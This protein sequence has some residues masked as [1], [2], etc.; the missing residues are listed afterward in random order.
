MDVDREQSTGGA[1]GDAGSYSRDFQPI[2]GVTLDELRS[3]VTKANESPATANI[4]IDGLRA[5]IAENG[6]DPD[7]VIRAALA[8]EP[9]VEP[10]GTEAGLAHAMADFQGRSIEVKAPELEQI[11]II[12]RLQR[13][14]S[15]AANNQNIDA[16]K[17][18]DL[19][20][21]ALRAITTVVVKPED[22]KLIEDMWLDGELILESTL[23]LLTT[24]MKV[25]ETANADQMNRQQRRTAQRSGSTSGRASLVT[26]G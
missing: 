15:T 21:R 20:D 24:A 7:S 18:L 16:E 23:P 12:R 5:L 25:L 11:V 3:I 9:A 10:A 8:E 4:V 22:K 19:M 6:H 1:G 14:L 17:A 13:E 2:P 26:G